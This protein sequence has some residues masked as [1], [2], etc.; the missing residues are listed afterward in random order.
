MIINVYVVTLI[1]HLKF[2][3]RN[4]QLVNVGVG[5]TIFFHPPI[6][7]YNYVLLIHK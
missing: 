5:M 7:L 1:V 4:L 6:Q 3:I 2:I